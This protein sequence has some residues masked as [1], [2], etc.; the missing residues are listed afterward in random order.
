MGRAET[1]W[2]TA[3]A[4][5]ATSA[6]ATSGPVRVSGSRGGRRVLQWTASGGAGASRSL[7]RAPDAEVQQQQAAMHGDAVLD[8]RNAANGR[9]AGRRHHSDARRERSR[10]NRRYAG[11][12]QSRSEPLTAERARSSAKLE[13]NE[14]LVRSA[15]R[16]TRA[17]LYGSLLFYLNL[18]LVRFIRVFP[19]TGDQV[20]SGGRHKIFIIYLCATLYIRTTCIPTKYYHDRLSAPPPPWGGQRSD[21]R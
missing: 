11:A 5:S 16:D 10:G 15:G 8:H 6:A 2:T 21:V 9:G 14:R 19:D 3:A 13:R 18:A 4:T 12:P 17:R 7:G 1:G 20:L